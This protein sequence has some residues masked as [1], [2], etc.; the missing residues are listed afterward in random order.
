MRRIRTRP[1]RSTW[2]RLRVARG[3]S[4]WRRA[5]YPRSRTISASKAESKNTYTAL[6]RARII[7][8]AARRPRFEV[9]N[10]DL[11]A[12]VHP[13]LVVLAL[14]VFAVLVKSS[15]FVVL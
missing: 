5:R 1:C 12:D 11:L 8:N 14:G 4:A 10:F 7:Q 15:G 6:F 9:F 3:G 13:S 2:K